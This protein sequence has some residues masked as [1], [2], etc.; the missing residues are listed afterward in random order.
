M[1]HGCL[2]G[3]GYASIVISFVVSVYYNVIMTWALY[4]FYHAFKKD[5]P[6]VGCDHSW[7]TENCYV[8]N[9]SNINGSGA[10]PSREFF[11]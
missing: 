7:N 5:I 1:L 2:S 11:V 8:H 10:S 4:Y 9:A 3:I 6:W